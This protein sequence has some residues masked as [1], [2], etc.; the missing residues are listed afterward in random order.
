MRAQE[1]GAKAVDGGDGGAFQAHGLFFQRAA[2]L[3]Q[4]PRQFGAQFRGRRARE[5][6]DEHLVDVRALG[7]QLHHA[8]HQ[9]RGFARTGR[10]R[11]QQ[12]FSA[13][14]YGRA[15]FLCEW[16]GSSAM[17]LDVIKSIAYCKLQDSVFNSHN[18]AVVWQ[19]LRRG[20]AA[21]PSSIQHGRFA[22]CAKHPRDAPCFIGLT[23]ACFRHW[24]RPSC[25]PLK[26]GGITGGFWTVHLH[27]I[28]PLSK[29]LP[30]PKGGARS[31]RC[32]RSSAKVSLSKPRRGGGARTRPKGVRSPG[33]PGQRSAGR[34]EDPNEAG[35]AA[36]ELANIGGP[37]G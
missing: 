30:F 32:A 6:D 10:R 14:F 8:L 18:R 5:R 22:S 3:H 24:R 34:Y 9:H 16:H 25:A 35:R 37:K 28:V 33:I 19:S 11:D 7:Q 26:K 12:I 29:R 23:T 17:V 13:R 15:L 20:C 2:C 36:S 31:A 21:P 4:P 27:A 1:L